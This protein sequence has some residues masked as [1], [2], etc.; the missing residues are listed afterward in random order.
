MNNNMKNND[1]T[2][3]TQRLILR[4]VQAEDFEAL[5]VLDMDPEV[6]SYFPEGVLNREE[7]QKELD[8]Y[9]REWNTIGFGIFAAIEKQSNQLIGRCGFAKLSSGVVE[10]GYLFLQPKWGQG[11][12]TEA[13][14]ALLAWATQHISVDHITGFAPANHIASLRVLEKCGMKFVK[15]DSYRNIECAFYKF[16]LKG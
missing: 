1:A 4:P 14:R 10:F 5:C 15:M 2:V 6:R 8:R 13:S 16:D 12:A 3:E 7:V 11:Y 9:I